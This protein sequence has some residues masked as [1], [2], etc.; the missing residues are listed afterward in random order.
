MIQNRFPLIPIILLI[1]AFV[2]CQSGPK[3]IP[4]SADDRVNVPPDGSDRSGDVRDNPSQEI[5][6]DYHTVSVNEVLPTEK[7]VYLYVT[8]GKETFW[9]ATQ[10]MNA[11]IGEEYIYKGSVR[12]TD[13][14]SE[15][16]DRIFEEVYFVSEIIPAAHGMEDISK[17]GSKDQLGKN[18]DRSMD[19][20]DIA[21]EGSLRIAD[22]VANPE[23]YEN[24]DVQIS[25]Q[26][27]KVNTEIMGLNWI[28]LKDGSKDDFDL[29]ITSSEMVEVGK[30]VTMKG[31]VSLNRD[32]GAG[33]RYD[34]IIENAK[35]VQ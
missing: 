33:Y 18:M 29:V 31:K 8:E 27:T 23:K 14:R 28:H 12:M 3:I 22:L 17:S 34:I 26:C 2:A 1:F 6:N 10:K 20:Q 16:H 30:I 11:S 7:Y 32:F 21:V 9:I 24:Q 35:I 5:E 13:F 4:P 15:E 25:G 19:V